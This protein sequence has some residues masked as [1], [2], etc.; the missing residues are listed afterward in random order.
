MIIGAVNIVLGQVTTCMNKFVLNGYSKKPS[1]AQLSLGEVYAPNVHFAPPIPSIIPSNQ[2]L[3][4]KVVQSH[5]LRD[6]FGDCLW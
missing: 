3:R 1:G 2:H 5:N 4:I 6:R